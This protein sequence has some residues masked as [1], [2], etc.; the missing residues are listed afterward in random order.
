MPWER[1]KLIEIKKGIPMVEKGRRMKIRE[2]IE[3]SV[4]N[5]FPIF[6]LI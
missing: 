6:Y 5:E 4:V 3:F 1:E 2:A